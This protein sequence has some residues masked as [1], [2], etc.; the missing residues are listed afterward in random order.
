MSVDYNYLPASDGTGDASLMHVQSTRT[1]GST[2]INVDSVVGVPLDFI[3]T[4]GTLL[5]TGFIDPTTKTDFKGHVSSLTL[6]IDSFEPGSTDIGNSAGQV[7][8][9]KPT[10]GW[11]NRVAQFIKDMTGFGTPEAVTTNTISISQPTSGAPALIQA[12]G[13][14]PNVDIQV[15]GK[16]S[17]VLDL[18]VPHK[19]RVYWANGAAS[20]VPASVNTKVPF[21]SVTYDTGSDFDLITNH[22]YTAKVAGLHYF[23]AVVCVNPA[24]NN[25]VLN[26]YLY[27]N[28]NLWATGP[29]GIAPINGDYSFGVSD[30]VM[31]NVGDYVEVYVRHTGAYLMGILGGQS[32]TYFSGYWLSKT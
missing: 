21:D 1:I 20:Y 14:D 9:I 29:Y 12:V 5:A 22:R 32:L 31:L 19:F 16:G 28:G 7:V 23:N 25:E 26:V 3:A 15:K 10:T 4:S 24:G 27:I 11:A 30:T 6:V 2:I 13:S 8:V 17:G 18:A